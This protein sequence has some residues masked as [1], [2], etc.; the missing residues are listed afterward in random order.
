MTLFTLPASFDAYKTRNVP[1][2]AG[3]MTSSGSLSTC[4]YSGLA[5]CKTKVQSLQASVQPLSLDKSA[6][7]NSTASACSFDTPPFRSI[8]LTSSARRR[9]RTV[10]RIL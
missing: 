7:T 10:V 9:E 6:S 8:C 1:S 2:L 5:T 4:I 3:L